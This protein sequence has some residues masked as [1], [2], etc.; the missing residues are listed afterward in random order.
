MQWKSEKMFGKERGK[1]VAEGHRYM[2]VLLQREGCFRFTSERRLRYIV[3][4]ENNN[5][6]NNKRKKRFDTILT[7][8][9]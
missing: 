6:D 5:N 7:I 3:G 4:E 8:S 2:L 9:G 1:W